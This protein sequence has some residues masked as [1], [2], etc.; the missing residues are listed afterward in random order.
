[1]K[2]PSSQQFDWTPTVQKDPHRQ[3]ASGPN[4]SSSGPF[5]CKLYL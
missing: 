1:M 4:V 5:N 3:S 2:T